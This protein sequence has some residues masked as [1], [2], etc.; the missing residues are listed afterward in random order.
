MKIKWGNSVEVLST[1][2]GIKGTRHSSSGYFVY[3]DV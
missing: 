3:I 2:P 1:V